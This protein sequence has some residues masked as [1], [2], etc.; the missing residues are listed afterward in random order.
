M[1]EYKKDTLTIDM[2]NRKINSMQ[3]MEEIENFQNKIINQ[4]PKVIVEIGTANGGTLSRWLEIPSAEIIVSID[5]PIGVHGGQGYEERMC[6]ISE[7]L[8]NSNLLNKKFYSINGDSKDIKVIEKLEIV[9]N[10]K[11]IDFLF[12][13]GDHTYEGVKSDFENYKKFLKGGS[14]VGFHDIIDSEYHKIMGCF[15]SKLWNDL[16]KNYEYVE[17]IYTENINDQTIKDPQW[18]QYVKKNGGFGGIG[19][20]YYKEKKM[21]G[22]T[23]LAKFD[24]HSSMGILSQ[25]IIENLKDTDVSCKKIIGETQTKNQKILSLLNKEPNNEI[26]I[27]FSYPDMIGELDQF[28]IKVI[29]TGVDTSGGIPNFAE[30]CNKADFLLTPSLI[31]KQRMIDL[32]VTKPIFLFPHGIEKNKFPY[33][34]RKKDEVFKFLYVGECSDR[35]GTF[36][37][38]TAFI[39]L[40]KNNPNVELHLRSN[41]GMLFYG[42]EKLKNLISP[43]KNIIWNH[44]NTTQ[45]ELSKLYDECHA[46]V[47][48]SRADTFGM[49]LLEA[50][51]SGLPIISTMEPGAV[52]LIDGRYDAIHTKGV[53]VEGHPWMLGE[54]GEPDLQGLKNSMSF[55][56]GNYDE[57]NWDKIEEHSKFVNENYS[58]EKITERFELGILPNLK[59]DIKVLTLLTSYERPNHIPNVIESLIDIR[60]TGIKNDVY[61]VENSE[62]DK[63]TEIIDIIN[64]KID[65]GFKLYVSEFNMGQRGALLQLLDDINIDD[66]DFIQFTDQDNIFVEP[67]S[68]YCNILYE[69]PE[70]GFVT[71]YMSKE[72]GELGWRETKFGSLCEKRSLR[73]GHMFMRVSDLKNLYPLHLDAHYGQPYNSS[74]Y[75]GL[76]WEL[77]YWNP[78]SIGKNSNHNFV[79]CVPGGVL[80]VGY[81]STF[82]E[83]PVEENEYQLEELLSMR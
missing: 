45:D 71:G 79:L 37:L 64:S 15:V 80:H 27:M 9:L 61:I 17:F 56:Y 16:K 1:S 50:M 49:T 82:Y 13:D 40:F 44:T 75:A 57:L 2:E 14:V 42:G 28:K 68:T 65:D 48:P 4:S 41:D 73:A 54:W 76:D 72:H 77:T 43:H 83:W 29:Y 66:Y 51:S 33:K 24:D 53:K 70:I 58:W 12:I 34:K 55:I 35:K 36:H 22:F 69:Y 31:S 18:L 10:G 63:K 67:I 6:V 21:N 39:D 30:N 5:Y 47:Y 74:W 26:G 20:I 60:E 52:E 59:K 3:V 62:S 25:K 19:M 23:W 38:V 46:Y 7:A 32:G 8:E 11:K 78:K 81:D